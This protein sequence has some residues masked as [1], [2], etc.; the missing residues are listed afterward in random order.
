MTYVPLD[1]PD[2]RTEALA[3]IVWSEARQHPEVVDFR[4]SVLRGR[5]LRSAERVT[6]WVEARADA[7]GEPIVPL[8]VL[9]YPGEGGEEHPRGVAVGK[10]GVLG[11]LYALVVMLTASYPWQ[12]EQALVFVLTDYRPDLPRAEVV[13]VARHRRFPATRTI[14]LRLSPRLTEQEVAA[15]YARARAEVGETAQPRE[16]QPKHLALAVFAARNNDGRTWEEVSHAWNKAQS[17]PEL[18]YVAEGASNPVMRFTRDC[19]DAYR[20]VTGARLEWKGGR[21]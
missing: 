19:R 6:A 20:R 3:Q 12:P 11:R 15:I 14:G 10:G 18:R 13:E 2:D 17:E 5:L 1:P 21:R 7:E 4:R 8:K 9:A 16:L